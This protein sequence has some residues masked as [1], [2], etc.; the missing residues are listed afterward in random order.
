[1]GAG[2][3]TVDLSGKWE[4][5]VDVDLEGIFGELT[6]WL[7]REAGVRV[8]VEGALGKVHV[9]GLTK[10]GDDYVNDAHGESGVALRID[11]T[12]GVGQV[13]LAAIR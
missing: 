2:N 1:M 11:I 12:G 13:N 9:I 7:P 8:G 4:R 3:V 6:V 5:D 10:D